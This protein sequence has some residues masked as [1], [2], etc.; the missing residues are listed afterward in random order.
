[1]RLKGRVKKR[2]TGLSATVESS[3]GFTLGDIHKRSG[4]LLVLVVLLVLLL[5]FLNC[6]KILVK[7]RQLENVVFRQ[8]T[9]STS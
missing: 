2:P 5:P 9:V 4:L 6:C 3:E 7:H 1:M 8:L